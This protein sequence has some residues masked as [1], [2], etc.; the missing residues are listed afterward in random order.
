MDVDGV[1]GAR[2]ESMAAKQ[3]S[4][5]SGLCGKLRGDFD[6]ECHWCGERNTG[7]LLKLSS[8]KFSP[9]KSLVWFVLAG[10][11]MED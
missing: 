10:Q 6:C 4:G 1:G 9:Q 7:L 5:W 8:R 2:L 11:K 3:W